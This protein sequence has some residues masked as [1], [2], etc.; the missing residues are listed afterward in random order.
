VLSK[1]GEIDVEKLNAS[2]LYL[3]EVFGGKEE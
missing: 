3:R 2:L 1:S